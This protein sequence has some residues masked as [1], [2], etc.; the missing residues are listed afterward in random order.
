MCSYR[1]CAA[2]Y[3][4]VK[5]SDTQKT[6]KRGKTVSGYSKTHRSLHAKASNDGHAA[7]DEAE[8]AL[9]TPDLEKTMVEKGMD[10]LGKL[11]DESQGEEEG[12]EKEEK[13]PDSGSNKEVRLFIFFCL[14]FYLFILSSFVFGFRQ[15]D[16]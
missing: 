15:L 5:A 12:E 6:S 10:I 16:L 2:I 7:S 11:S 13:A 1:Y 14:L 3:F 9:E 4:S 8:E